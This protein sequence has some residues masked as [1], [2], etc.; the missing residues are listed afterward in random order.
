MVVRV[1]AKWIK[2]PQTELVREA[3]LRLNQAKCEFALS[4]AGLS[5]NASTLRKNATFITRGNKEN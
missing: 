4:S 5:R 2:G 3:L 1:N